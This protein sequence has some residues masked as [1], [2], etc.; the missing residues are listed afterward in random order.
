MISISHM[1]VS[2]VAQLITAIPAFPT[3]LVKHVPKITVLMKTIVSAVATLLGAVLSAPLLAIAR[4]V[5]TT[6][7]LKTEPACPVVYKTVCMPP[8]WSAKLAMEVI[9]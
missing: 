3:A 1:I 2:Q 5:R 8:T 7:A 9:F 4:S 6:I